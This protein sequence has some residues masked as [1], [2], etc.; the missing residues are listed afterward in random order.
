MS[1]HD[2]AHAL[3]VAGH[4]LSDGGP[5]PSSDLMVASLLHDVGKGGTPDVPG[6]VR[7]PDRTAKVLLA[8]LAPRALDA[9]TRHPTLPGLYLAVHHPRLGAHLVRAAGGT[10][11]T[12]WLVAAHEDGPADNQ[13]LRRLMAADARSH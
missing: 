8:R 1:P 3:R 4:V 2:R 9:L 13:D 11:R 10:D 7:L 6:R 12:C 5:A